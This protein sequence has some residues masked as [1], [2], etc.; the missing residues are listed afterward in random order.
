MVDVVVVGGGAAGLS[1]AVALGRV[2]RSVVVIDSGAPRNAPSGGV[3]MLL[4]RDGIS[5]SELTRI[6]RREVETYGGRVIDGEAVSATRTPAGFEVTLA[7]GG[8]VVGRRLLV[9]TGLVDELPEIAGLQ[10]LWGR[11]VHHCPFCHGWELAGKSVGVI[12]SGPMAVHQ[13]LM[14][15]QLVDDLVL[16]QHTAPDLTPDQADQLAAR[17]IRVVPGGVESVVMAD[18]RLAGIRL[19][20]GEIVSREALVVAPQ[21]IAR[22]QLLVSLG[23]STTEHAMGVGEFIAADPTGQTAVPGVWVAGKV[24]DLSAGVVQSAAAGTSAGAA[25]NND[26]IGEDTRAAVDA[27]RAGRVGMALVDAGS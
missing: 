14:F 17:G 27:Y 23:L 2:R 24:T 8:V 6:G 4:T 7:G 1:G 12:G 19:A 5:P 18:G 10:E 11:D 9:T 15:R 21:F 20:N 3:H 26:L 16:F 25:I 13:A 22:S